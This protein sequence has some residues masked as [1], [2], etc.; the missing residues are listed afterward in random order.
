MIRLDLGKHHRRCD[1]VTRRDFLQIGGIA[2]L[3]LPTVL[4]SE[5]NGTD[6]AT[7]PSHATAKSVILVYLGGGLSHH[8]SFDP[9]P[10]AP[11]EVRGNYSAIATRVSSVR[12]GDKIPL[13]AARNNKFALIRS[14]T[15]GND[16]H[17]TATNW[18]LS[19]RFGSPFGDF[20]AI[21]AVVAHE[22]GYRGPMPPYFA[23]PR[24]PSFTWE[25]G[26]SAFLGGRYESF[27][28]GDP[29]DPNFRVQD[30][31][32][33]KRAEGRAERRQ[34]LR[35]A[36]DGLAKQV[37]ADDQL[38]TMDE[39]YGRALDLVLSS[40]ARQAFDI[41]RED[42]RLRDRY[43]RNTTGQ[44]CLLARR[45]VESGVRFVTVNSGGWDHHAKIFD[46]LD[47]RLP[48]LD[49]ALSAL[50]DDLDS[51]GLLEST[52]VVCMGEF[53]RSPKVNKEAGRD[54]W[55]H[56]ASV[57]FAGG[58]VKPGRVIGASDDQ[59]GRVSDRPVRPAD[60]AATIYQAVGVDYSRHLVTPENR[61]VTILDDGSPVTELVA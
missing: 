39:F 44:S 55:G 25:L 60:V 19:G 26:K 11:V 4:R 59:G 31:T 28:S 27:K 32:T 46:S 12:F 35:Q 29:N 3:G 50:I 47:K 58:G 5:A 34:S 54:H 30:I 40:E 36:I 1:G 51:R 56:V 45:L 49:F 15:H 7:N 10:D 9:K 42:P 38:R 22:L 48:E 43:G 16:H 33:P 23:V 37:E 8:D 2:A 61:P 14:A 17:E 21:G 20:P 24:N 41:P 13:L 6:S 18:V 53:G 52:L 57:L